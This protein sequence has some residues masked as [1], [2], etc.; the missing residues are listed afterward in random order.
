MKLFLCLLLAVS[1]AQSV[2]AAEPQV[3]SVNSRSDVLRGD[4]RGVSI[5]QDG[6]IT[7]APQFTETLKTGQQ[8]I[9][10]SALNRSGDLYV[11]TGPEGKIFRVDSSGKSA[12]LADLAEL[13]VS[14]LAIGSDGALFAATSPDGKVYRIDANGK[15]EVYFEPKEKYIWS[16]AVLPDG[17][18]VATGDSGKIFKVKAAGASATSSLLYDTSETHVISLAARD[19]GEL[20]AG[21]DSNGLVMR[22]GRDG[23]PFGLLDSPLREVHGL[24]VG[25]DGSVYVLVIG[26]SVSAPKPEAAQPATAPENKPV[27]LERTLPVETP[28]KSR[29]D[30]SAARSAVY[31]ILPDGSSDLLWA[32]PSVVGFSIE[33]DRSGRGALIGTSDKGRIYEISNTG[34]EK[35]IAQT[36]ASQISTLRSTPQA[37]FATS[38][39]QGSVYRSAA[40]TGEGTYESAVLDSRS[41]SSWG[42]IWW[43]SSG[44][45]SIQTRTGNTEKPDETWSDWSAA[46]SDQKG[47]PISSPKARY[48]QWKATLRP[49]RLGADPDRTALREVNLAFS[50]RNIQPE[51]L[52]LTVLPTNVGL[53]SNPP[54]QIDPNIELSGMDPVT[55]GLPNAA[56]PPRRVW[57]RGAV[58]LQW[59]AEDRNGDKLVY[60]VYFREIGDVAFKLLRGGLTDNFLAVD[61]QALADGRYVFRVVARDTPSN[62]AALALSGDR[63]TEPVDIDNTPPVV[64]AAGTPQTVGNKTRLVFEAADA[65]GYITRG[66]YSVNGGEWISVYPDDGISDSPRERFTIEVNPTADA[67]EYAVAIRVYDAVGNSGAARQVFRR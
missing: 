6:T 46:S 10:S 13:N 64:T 60:D 7:L 58:S 20:F 42:R 48:I 11:G 67:N 29:Y 15:V 50:P 66:E 40:G 53:A 45:V 25:P 41:T 19:G 28:V 55:F 26:D 39:N 24:S 31:R 59:T 33:A 61:G 22:F 65:T 57:Q 56:V 9:W 1:L 14:A 4:A 3:W 36:D 5:D 43:R 12:E 35:L 2:G 27:T 44:A 32:S 30:L 8:Y 23:R 54:V 18:A 63:F 49:A 47:S 38:S 51:I 16:L 52:S 37:L 17:L 21:T 62:P 34:N